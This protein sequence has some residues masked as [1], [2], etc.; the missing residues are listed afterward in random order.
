M[1]NLLVEALKHLHELGVGLA[2]AKLFHLIYRRVFELYGRFI[3]YCCFAF[4]FRILVRS[5]LSIV[6]LV[7]SLKGVIICTVLKLGFDLG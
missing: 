3:F 4:T 2:R 6:L 1:G 7:G 5:Q